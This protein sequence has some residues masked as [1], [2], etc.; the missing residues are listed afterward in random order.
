VSR[1]PILEEIYAA[2]AMLIEEYHGDLHA[3]IEDT[4]R[5]TLASGHP[6]APSERDNQSDCG[7]DL[8]Q[9]GPE[10]EHLLLSAL[11]EALRRQPFE[12]F[13]LRLSD[14][15]QESVKHPEFVAIGPRV[16][17]IVRP[18]NSV[19]KV[20]PLLIVSLEHEDAGRKAQDQDG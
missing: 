5:R 20:E 9:V 10:D 2:R 13:T 1:N 8:R 14:G 15:R 16:V 12:P 3:Y 18:D 7:E 11:R 17:V 19:L 4:W 6:I